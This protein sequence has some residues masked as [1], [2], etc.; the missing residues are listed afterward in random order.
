M[1]SVTSIAPLKR[2]IHHLSKTPAEPVSGPIKT[3]YILLFISLLIYGI[4]EYFSV[5][6]SLFMLFFVHYCISLIYMVVL[7]FNSSYGINRSWKK[8]NISKT[9]VLL[10]LFLISAFALNRE[11]VVFENS[12]NWLCVYILISSAT[13]LS[14]EYAHRLPPWVNNLQHFLLGSAV[15]LYLYLALYVVNFYPVGALGLIV[16]G[17]G[18]HIFVPLTLLIA[19]ICLFRHYRKQRINNYSVIAGFLVPVLIA[20]AFTLEWN[21]RIS[22]LERISNQSAMSGDTDLPV[23]VKIAESLENDWISERILKTDL[24]F[25]T[26]N[27]ESDE[28]RFMPRGVSWDETKKHDPLVYIASFKS[29]SNLI[30]DERVKIIKAISNGRHQANERLW[31]GENLTTSYIISDIDI[32]TDLRLAYTEQYL[33]IR[34][35]VGR[36]TWRGGSQEG[37]YTFYLPPGSV[38]TSLSLWINGQ[39]EKGILTSKQKAAKAYNTIVGVENR[40]PSVV[41]WQEGNTVTVRVFPC[42]TREERKFKIGITSPLKVQDGNIVYENIMFDGPDAS[43]AGATRRIRFIGGNPKFVATDDFIKNAKGDYISEKKYDPEFTFSYPATALK[44]NRFSYNGYSYSLTDLRPLEVAADIHHIFLD[45]N[46]SWLKGEPGE[47]RDLLVD[48]QVYGY[49]DQEMIK[50]TDS[51][52]SEVTTAMRARNFSLFPFQKLSDIGH[53]LVITKGN[54]LSPHLIDINKSKFAN[55]ISAFFS[56]GKKVRVFNI[57]GKKST[58][59]ASLTELR[60]LECSEGNITS[61]K[62]MLKLNIFSESGETDDIVALPEAR[63]AITRTVDSIGNEPGNAPDHLLRLFAYN[64]IMRKAGRGYFNDDYINEAL[65]D[66]AATAYIVSPV[67]SLIVLET[68]EDYKRFDIADKGDSLHNAARQSSG[69]VPEPHEWVLIFMF[70]AFALYLKF[71][72][73]SLHYSRI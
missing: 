57:A 47:L 10:N 18:G 14:Y 73:R 45:I 48:H 3:G 49:L 31:S 21:S 56:S 53:S 13:L 2:K 12:V 41:H 33:N 15:A 66:E 61:L 11:M 23:W 16:L 37:I 59:I 20:V 26:V 28:W 35:N 5:Q 51:N 55:D 46:N 71:R 30:D 69:S 40:D 36:D 65:V 42:T 25:T 17:L 63:M 38:V 39:E 43:N 27:T 62:K 64:D 68:R 29:R 54:R 52:W 19:S 34:N 8:E 50:L 9:V 7:I 72:S 6:E 22:N 24:V 58:Y 70:L 67:S 60:G 44:S 1:D 32:Y 4:C